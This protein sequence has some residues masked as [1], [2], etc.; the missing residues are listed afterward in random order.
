MVQF[1][2][3]SGKQAGSLWVARRF[4]VRIGRAAGS[5]LR[6]D[7]DGVWDEHLLLEVRAGEGFQLRT[8]GEALARVNGQPVH[9]TMLRNGDY[10]QIGA[11]EL[12][13]WLAEARQRLLGFREVLTWLMIASMV[14]A[15]IALLYWLLKNS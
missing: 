12:Q 1:K 6:L 2:I 15:Q 10:L 3:L 14:A 5:D 8:R 4:P 13:F 9:E 11:A 7:E